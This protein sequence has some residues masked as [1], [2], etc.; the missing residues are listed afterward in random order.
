MNHQ[1]RDIEIIKQIDAYLKDQLSEQETRE[2]WVELLKNQEY[3]EYL[4][5]EIAVKSILEERKNRTG[6]G[7]ESK[8]SELRQSWKWIA[9]AA[10]VAIL[11]IAINFLKIDSS[12]P[13]SE[14]TVGTI[15]MTSNLAAPMVMRS[16]NAELTG[17]DSLMNVGFEAALSGDIGR[18]VQMYERVILQYEDTPV[19]ARAH[20]NIGIIRYNE[21][22]FRT[23][24][25]AFQQAISIAEDA[26]L[27]KEKA[28][29]YLGNAY[30]NLDQLDKARAAIQKTYLLDGTY[31][32][33]AYRLL[34]KLDYELGNIDFQELEQ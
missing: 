23:A 12:T 34:R 11:V 20:L 18:A 6:E 16:Q 2:F 28:Y 4:E 3:L 32:K 27:L 26:D 21:G 8:V 14:Q 30:I 1:S 31:R 13:L 25:D 9:A 33:P 7:P 29:W 15:N 22:D 17:A 5:T 19:A 10:S 24:S